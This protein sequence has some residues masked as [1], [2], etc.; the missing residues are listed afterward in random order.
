MGMN[1]WCGISRAIVV[2]NVSNMNKTQCASGLMSGQTI[3]MHHRGGT[4]DRGQSILYRSIGTRSRGRTPT[5]QRLRA[6]RVVSLIP[7]GRSTVGW[8]VDGY[9]SGKSC[10][11]LRQ[12]G[13]RGFPRFQEMLNA[14]AGFDQ[15]FVRRREAYPYE[16]FASR[17]ERIA[18]NQRH[19]LAIQQ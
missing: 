9:L 13:A 5:N 3:P 10:I 6:G 4:R 2:E 14:V 12:S 7:Y 19:V 17:S 8:R 18:G 1:P 15:G 11:K 16:S